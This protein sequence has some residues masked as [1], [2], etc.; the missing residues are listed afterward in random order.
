M[1]YLYLLNFVSGL[2]NLVKTKI[3]KSF[4]FNWITAAGDQKREIEPICWK[5]EGKVEAKGS[6]ASQ[7]DS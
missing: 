1:I 6:H 5:F 3:R 4:F 7:Y 2:L